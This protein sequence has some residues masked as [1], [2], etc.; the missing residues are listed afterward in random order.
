MTQIQDSNLKNLPRDLG[1]F[2]EVGTQNA[3]VGSVFYDDEEESYALSLGRAVEQEEVKETYSKWKGPSFA[4]T[5]LQSYVGFLSNKGATSAL[6]CY[7]GGNRQLGTSPV[8]EAR[9]VYPQILVWGLKVASVEELIADSVVLRTPT[10]ENHGNAGISVSSKGDGVEVREPEY[11][12]EDASNGVQVIRELKKRFGKK[13]EASS[14]ILIKRMFESRISL[15]LLEEYVAEVEQFRLF[16]SGDPSV[17]ITVQIKSGRQSGTV[18]FDTIH[19]RTRSSGSKIVKEQPLLTMKGLAQCLSTWSLIFQRYKSALYKANTLL[20]IETEEEVVLTLGRVLDDIAG[21]D[22]L[23]GPL[24]QENA[25]L[26]RKLLRRFRKSL[27]ERTDPKVRRE[28]QNL[29]IRRKPSLK[30]TFEQI[31]A[32]LPYRQ[33]AALYSCADMFAK[34]R[35]SIAHPS[36][37]S[38]HR[39]FTA[40]A[41]AGAILVDMFF[42]SKLSF[43]QE[44]IDTRY[45]TKFQLLQFLIGLKEEE[46]HSD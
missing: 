44:V 27:P 14:E 10:F 22:D 33:A 16:L 19:G 42:C 21:I 8:F 11:A 40:P 43:S 36:G 2:Q 31:A 34:S 35:N 5:K 41:I 13:Y 15:A 18:L 26:A 17:P 6:I 7:P 30:R 38:V 23:P 25:L 24:E 45:G 1:Y 32:A 12:M 9:L 20:W 37:K 28:L 29:S 3:W 46:Y 4:L 39:R